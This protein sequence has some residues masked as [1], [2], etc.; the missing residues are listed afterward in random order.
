MKEASCRSLD[1]HS[2]PGTPSNSARSCALRRLVPAAALQLLALL[3]A[4]LLVLPVSGCRSNDMGSRGTAID[5]SVALAAP[6]PT[7]V[8]PEWKERLAT[9]YVY[10]EHVGDYREVGAALRQLFSDARAAGIEPDGVP[11]TLFYD[12][13]GVIP[14]DRL[15]ARACLPIA[16][17]A[18]VPSR[19][20]KDILPQAM[21]VYGRVS[22][23]Y[24]QVPRSY[25][26]LL[27]YL[28]D[29]SWSQ[30][31]PI[32]EVY[33]VDPGSVESWDQL[34]TEVQI[35]WTVR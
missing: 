2:H 1:A 35:P 25:P 22:G 32:R 13:P 5:A 9:A 10:V 12:D 24:D 11:F 33:L 26:K 4:P 6:A 15:R 29:H 31:G 34:V 7:D 20:S 14:R 16:A 3:F 28:E 21:V 8:V 18:S 23:A 17:G 30:D 19:L 27:A